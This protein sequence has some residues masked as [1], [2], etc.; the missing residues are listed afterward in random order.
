MNEFT[1]RTVGERAAGA[2]AIIRSDKEWNQE[3]LME[4]SS[5]SHTIKQC[6]LIQTGSG[7]SLPDQI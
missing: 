6:D 4:Y 5:S 3:V 7:N 1:Q 2:Q